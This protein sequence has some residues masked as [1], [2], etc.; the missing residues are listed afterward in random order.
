VP[1]GTRNCSASRPR[2]DRWRAW[3]TDSAEVQLFE[4]KAH[5]GTST[6]TLGVL[7][8]EP[9]RQRLQQAGLDPG[10]I[11]QAD[12]FFIMRMHDPDRNLVVFASAR[13]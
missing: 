10:P 2:A 12:N 7:P 4:D 13:R 6:L 1:P 11:E 3:F 5:A 8:L 9:E